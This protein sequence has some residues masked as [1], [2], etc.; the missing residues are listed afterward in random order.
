MRWSRT[1]D[2][3]LISLKSYPLDHKSLSGNIHG[4]F[5][6]LSLKKIFCIDNRKTGDLEKN[7][8][9]KYEKIA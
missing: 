3:T 7:Q 8:Y 2:L 6:I 1:H 5:I 9:P 4:V